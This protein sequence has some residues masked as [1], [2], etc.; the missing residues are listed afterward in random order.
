[1]TTLETTQ[2]KPDGSSE[3]I[4]RRVISRVVDPVHSRVR[5]TGVDSEEQL[6]SIHDGETFETVDSEGNSVTVMRQRTPSV[7]HP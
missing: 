2:T 4:T 3:T 7:I 6:R 1:M 5:F